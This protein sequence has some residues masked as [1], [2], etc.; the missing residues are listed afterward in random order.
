M[1]PWKAQALFYFRTAFESMKFSP[2]ERNYTTTEQEMLAMYFALQ[3]WRCYLEGPKF[4]LVTDHAPNTYFQTQ[5][6]LSRRQ[7]RWNE[8]FQRF[9]FSWEYR[10]GR[11]NIADPLSRIPPK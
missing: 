5:P 6:T 4:V 2:P 10:P 9:D 3:K 7:A 11:T 8:F 1:H